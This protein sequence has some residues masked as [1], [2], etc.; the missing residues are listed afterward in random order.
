[1]TAAQSEVNAAERVRQ[2]E[3]QLAAFGIYWKPPR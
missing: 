3:E 2:S 1:L